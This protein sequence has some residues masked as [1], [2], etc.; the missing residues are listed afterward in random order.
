M[1]VKIFM[2]SAGNFAEADLLHAMGEGIEQV[3]AELNSVDDA[4]SVSVDRKRSDA[5]AYT[6][7]YVWDDAYTAC[8]LAVI[9][10]SWKPREKAHHVVRT[11]VAAAAMRFLVIETALLNRRTDQENTYWRVGVNGYLGR[12]A[13][14]PVLT[15]DACDARL[16]N[17]GI[18][19][20]KEWTHKSNGHI[21]LGL[22]IPGDASLRGT[23]IYAWAHHA[24][25]EIRK[26]SD[27]KILIRPHPLTSDKGLDDLQR[28]VGR[29]TL[30]GIKNLSYSIDSTLQQDLKNAYCSVVFSSGM[31]VDSVLAGIPVLCSDSS[32]FAWP[33]CTRN[34]QQIENL[35]LPDAKKISAWLRHLSCCQW[36]RQELRSGECFT[37]L[38]PII[39]SI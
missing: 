25:T 37:A 14:W 19:S 2:Q 16:E 29:L 26:T 23:D 11:S 12:D 38:A 9:Y 4:Q 5:N 33:V 27:R 31:S 15:D 8:D 32:N 7:D 24:I 17:I 36:N 22:Q 34:L 1:R 30:A 20:W 35:T 3:F 28:F 39:E 10:G 21:L 18:D 13:R 6:V